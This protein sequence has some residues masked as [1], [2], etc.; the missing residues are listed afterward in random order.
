[1][2]CRIVALHTALTDHDPANSNRVGFEEVWSTLFL[3]W[4]ASDKLSPILQITQYSY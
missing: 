3:C 2:L 1:M 4:V